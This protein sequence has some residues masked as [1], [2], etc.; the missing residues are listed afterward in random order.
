M[1]AANIRVKTFDLKGVME[2]KNQDL[3]SYDIEYPQFA[4]DK[5]KAFINKLNIYYKAD[6][7]L[8]QKFHVLKLYQMAIDDYEY[9]TKNGFPVREYEVVVKYELTYNQDCVISLYIDRY[10]YTGGAHGMTNRSADTWSLDK[11]K[12]MLLADFFPGEK[13]YRQQI[14]DNINNQIKE[15]IDSGNDYYFDDYENLVV[16]NFNERN[17]Y[18]VPEGL[19]IFFQ[20]YEIAPYS[21][22]IMNF[23]IPFEKNGAKQPYC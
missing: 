16:E 4:S 15:Q 12:R 17:F 18:L 19:T 20:L 7:S 6:A 9:A 3:L 5:F 1:A 13:D 2:Y 21:S 14:I 8:Y 23:L 10:E 11:S 22:G